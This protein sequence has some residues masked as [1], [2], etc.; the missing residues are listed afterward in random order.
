MN[1]SN[2][3]IAARGGAKDDVVV[4]VVLNHVI[5]A[6]LADKENVRGVGTA[7]QN[8]V[9]AGVIVDVVA[10]VKRG[11]AAARVDYGVV[12]FAAVKVHLRKARV[13][14]NRVVVVVAVNEGNLRGI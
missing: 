7:D 13:V 11:R 12:V 10:A 3:G 14:D 4:F 5:A 6:I 1:E 8:V 2:G 9:V